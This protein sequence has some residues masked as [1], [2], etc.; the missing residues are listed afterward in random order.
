[1]LDEGEITAK[2]GSAIKAV[3]R[4]PDVLSGAMGN[5]MY[6]AAFKTKREM[7]DF[8]REVLQTK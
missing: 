8:Y 1:M 5:R 3:S 2:Y 7:D 4:I 6:I